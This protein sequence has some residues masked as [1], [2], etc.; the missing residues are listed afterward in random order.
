[1][2]FDIG[3]V[4]MCQQSSV[5][6]IVTS[7]PTVTFPPN[8]EAMAQTQCCRCRCSLMHSIPKKQLPRQCPFWLCGS[9]GVGMSGLKLLADWP[10]RL[11]I[12]FT[13]LCCLMWIKGQPT[14]AHLKYYYYCLPHSGFLILNCSFTKELISMTLWLDKVNV[15]SLQVMHLSGCIT[16]GSCS[17]RSSWIFMASPRS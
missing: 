15:Q 9:L 16:G 14:S 3:S 5:P 2:V 7:G 6:S 12:K 13:W 1:M 4:G 10:T 8:T 17:V 11:G